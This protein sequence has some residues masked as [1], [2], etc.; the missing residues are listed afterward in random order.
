MVFGF[1][2]N[3]AKV[4][5][6]A[7]RNVKQGKLNH[8]IADYEKV[9]KE[10]PKD[11]TVMNAIG[12]LYARIGNTERATEYF[13]K[14]GDAYAADGFTVR[15][16]ALYK[17]LAKQD[18]NLLDVVLKLAE[19][20]TQQGLYNDARTQ[21]LQVAEYN[22]RNGELQKASNIFQKM[23]EL[24]P[25]NIPL[26][27]R[28]AE[29]FVRLGRTGEARDLYFRNAEAFRSRGALDQADDALGRVLKLDPAFNQAILLRG[30]VKLQSGD[31][32]TAAQLLEKLPDIDSHPEGL[33]TLL[34]AYI[35]T[36]KLTE[37]EPVARKILRVFSDASGVAAYGEALIASGA[38]E[39]AL[40]CYREHADHL[41]VSDTGK[42]AE[43][44]QSCVAK[45][46][47]NTSALEILSEL[48]QRAGKSEFV[49][50][51]TEL[52][53]HALVQDGD[54]ARARDYYQKLTAL[55][56]NN[57][58]H[59]QNYHQCLARLSGDTSGAAQP[60]DQGS[61]AV[62][63]E[64]VQTSTEVEQT[65]APETADAVEAALTDAE[66]FDSY[67]LATKAI[68]PLEKVLPRAPRDIRINRRLVSL[69]ARSGRMKEA[70]ERCRVLE[71]VY[72]EAGAASDAAQF[73]DLAAR[74]QE[75]SGLP[76][77]AFEPPV[78]AAVAESASAAAPAEQRVSAAD[79]PA[80]ARQ[81]QAFQ[82]AAT[83][84]STSIRP[85][86]E[87]EPVA[88]STEFDL[89]DEWDEML[90]VEEETEQP[91]ASAPATAS[92]SANQQTSE[93]SQSVAV[94]DSFEEI[95]SGPQGHDAAASDTLEEIRFYISQ[96]MWAEAQA[97]IHR[98]EAAYPE[99]SEL[100]ALKA[101]VEAAT[102][103]PTLTTAELLE[104]E[105]V[106]EA[107]AGEVGDQ[108]PSPASEARAEITSD[109]GTGDLLGGMVLD[110]EA[111]L[112]GLDLGPSPAPAATP[113]VIATQPG[114][115]AVP[116]GV[117][118]QAPPALP[119]SP[120]PVAAPAAGETEV[121][122]GLSD[123]FAEFKQ[124][125]EDG[126][127]TQEDPET[128]YNLGV[129]F[130]EMG[131]LDEAIGELQKVCLAVEHGAAFSQAMQAYTWLA[132]CFLQK[133][134]PEAAV[135]WY[136]KALKTTVIDDEVA[137]AIHYELACAHE[138][139]GNK[140]SA[141]KHFMEVYGTN[142]DYRD[143]AER[144]KALKS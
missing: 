38:H 97:A 93:T 63:I 117:R 51:V 113:P 100:V 116:A 76:A 83:I 60:M 67:N 131:L 114:T 129:A 127:E 108:P 10:D 41:L 122:G 77:S 132:D 118:E 68:G 53:A 50:E 101:E 141:L 130:K 73:A 48:F 61:Q 12:D 88:Q 30:A 18:P 44:L 24:D 49:V 95:S 3:K 92:T 128:H 9:I 107:P 133:G 106:D 64:E 87:P 81:E 82:A 96:G 47:S 26:Q 58:Q 16:I 31:P 59:V 111:S 43:V 135:R 36:G 102:A 29:L 112:G 72:L 71:S 52:L 42:L 65:L 32:E 105:V 39:Q 110:L 7:E 34:K 91:V 6:S 25:E 19:L 89:S 46:K 70:A 74:Y 84:G 40:R 94:F 138:A 35:D 23:L 28:L 104:V 56:P 20:Y 66:L 13:R 57:T 121:P 144:I 125:M 11:L 90:E 14:V 143:V 99:G 75:R 109:P 55:E 45:V 22:M 85:A 136:E 123:I 79:S 124:S 4:L 5:A 98:C 142:I 86:A 140:T 17:K 134:V 126:T 1:G 62:A 80:P 115:T 103:S 69:Y 139:A 137:T 15:A 78:K 54:I 37:A 119:A 21:Y 8:A 120:A 33:R 27:S 2:F